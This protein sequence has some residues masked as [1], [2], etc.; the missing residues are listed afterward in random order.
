MVYCMVFVSEIWEMSS[1]TFRNDQN[2]RYS[3]NT[4]SDSEWTHLNI[5]QMIFDKQHSVLSVTQIVLHK[6]KM[7]STIAYKTGTSL[8]TL[9]V[10]QLIQFTFVG[11][12]VTCLSSCNPPKA[13]MSASSSWKSNTCETQRRT[14]RNWHWNDCWLLL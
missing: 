12:Q 7:A 1:A 11:S 2:L 5:S 10:I 9:R 3:N 4:F 13:T 6:N 14:R 8:N